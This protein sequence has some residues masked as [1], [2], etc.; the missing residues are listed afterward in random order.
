MTGEWVS[1]AY[2]LAQLLLRSFVRCLN[3]NQHMHPMSKSNNVMRVQSRFSTTVPHHEYPDCIHL[4]TAI[5]NCTCS[6]LGEHQLAATSQ[7]FWSSSC[8]QGIVEKLQETFDIVDMALQCIVSASLQDVF[9]VV[10]LV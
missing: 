10:A 3:T 8:G 4:I 2:V 9:L 7:T 1:N 5:L 6:Q